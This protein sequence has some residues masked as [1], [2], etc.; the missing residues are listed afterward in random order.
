M[1]MRS[2]RGIVTTGMMAAAVYIASAFLQVSIPTVI[3]DTRLHMGNGICL[4]SGILLGPLYGGAAAGIGSMLFDLTSPSYISSAPFTLI[5]KFAMAWLCGKIAVK[6][7]NR[8]GFGAGAAA[9]A[10]LYAA[11][12]IAKNYLE[13]R[14]FYSMPLEAVL[15]MCLQKGAVSAIN[16]VLSVLVAVPLALAL[17]PLV[18]KELERGE[19]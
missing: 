9:G 14:V 18:Q 4:L 17:K 6:R 19:F 5:F 15:L 10:F 11:L 2:I 12:Y 8:V 7:P 13:Y 1:K 16:A 3:G